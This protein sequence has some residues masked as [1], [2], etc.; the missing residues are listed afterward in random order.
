MSKNKE[1][2]TP[3]ETQRPRPS[4]LSINICDS[5]IRDELT[6]KISLIGL[7]NTIRAKSFPCTHAGLYVYVAMTNGHGKY[8]MEVRFSKLE[9]GKAIASIQGQLNFQNPLQMVELSFSSPPLRFDTPGQYV[10]EVFCDGAQ[11]QT[12]KFRVVGSQQKT[13]PISGTE[14]G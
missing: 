11:I 9:E 2:T 6:K 13:P 10:V 14:A 12:R 8:K 3:K 5:V 1:N 7:F 4:V